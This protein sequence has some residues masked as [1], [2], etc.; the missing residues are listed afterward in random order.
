[1]GSKL[2][3]AEVGDVVYGWSP[4]TCGKILSIIRDPQGHPSFDRAKVKWE[5]GKIQTTQVGE[6]HSY[7]LEIAKAEQR[8]MAY[9]GKQLQGKRL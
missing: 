4:Q 2:W 9:K 6:L 3:T 1:M 8:I 7:E 5:D